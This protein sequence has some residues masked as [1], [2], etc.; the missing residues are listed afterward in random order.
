[1]RKTVKN[2]IK[3][4][5]GTILLTIIMVLIS[6]FF[7][8]LWLQDRLEI[9]LMLTAAVALSVSMTNWV[10]LFN[11]VI[12]GTGKIRLQMYAWLGASIIN[13][14]LSIFFATTL[15]MGTVGIVLGTIVSMIPLAIISP[16]QVRK[17]LRQTDRGIW[18]K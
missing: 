14:P 7:Y 18:S 11:L 15:E 17:L 1:M 12:N 16:M 13:I 5:G 9:P 10:N 6:P 3:I 4:W 8:K 2:V